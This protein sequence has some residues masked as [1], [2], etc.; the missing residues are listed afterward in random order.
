MAYVPPHKRG[1]GSS[2]PEASL[3][4]GLP[5]RRIE[6][7]SFY[8]KQEICERLGAQKLYTLTESPAT[9]GSLAL[10]AIHD[11]QHP[12]WPSTILCKSNLHLLPD[13]ESPDFS[14]HAREYPVFVETPFHSR[15]GRQ[16]MEYGGWW[17]IIRIEYLEP[18]SEELITMLERKFS[19]PTRK[20]RFGSNHRDQGKTRTAEAWAESLSLRW[21]VITLERNKARNDNPLNDF[22]EATGK[23]LQSLKTN[24]EGEGSEEVPKSTSTK[25]EF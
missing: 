17:K 5:T 8:T 11:G 22:T 24:V 10:I 12:G 9:P 7:S 6:E 15:K 21:A 25:D 23:Y 1:K 3:S 19:Q 18:Q 16:V 4:G 20:G 2:E 13:H 14:L